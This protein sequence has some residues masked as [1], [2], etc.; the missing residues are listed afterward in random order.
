[1]KAS[2]YL[3]PWTALRNAF[4][5]PKKT[6]ARSLLEGTEGEGE[7]G[8][9]IGP[10]YGIGTNREAE[11][12]HTAVQRSVQASLVVP[13]WARELTIKYDTA[14]VDE[15][16]G[17]YER[18]QGG[19][20]K[21]R[22]PGDESAMTARALALTGTRRTPIIEPRRTDTLAV[23]SVGGMIALDARPNDSASLGRVLGRHSL[24][25]TYHWPT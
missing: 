9:V 16:G 1:M 5:D 20:L 18:K 6:A 14:W 22:L 24:Q 10:R 23:G 8:W 25:K 21:L 12:S 11:F 13:G 4:S 3:S 17:E 7:F 2:N 15:K 19:E